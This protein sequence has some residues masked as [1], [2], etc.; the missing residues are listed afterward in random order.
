[1]AIGATSW[2]AVRVTTDAPT[3]AAD[4]FLDALVAE[5]FDDAYSQ[6]CPADRAERSADEF[7]HAVSG[8]TADLRGHDAFTLDS[9]GDTR[10]VHFTL[11][12]GNRTDEFDLE[13]VASNGTWQVC[14]FF[15]SPRGVDGSSPR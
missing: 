15:A 4:E 1:M 9:I 8:L 12:Y 3:R 10:T 14:N 7:A 13:V 6:L 2:L 11:A 5:R